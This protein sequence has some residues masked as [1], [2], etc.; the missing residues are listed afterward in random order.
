VELDKDELVT[1][2]KKSV[3]DLQQGVDMHTCLIA[4]ILGREVDQRTL[5][6]VLENCPSRTREM[7]MKDAIM[8]AI[9]ALD[10]SRKAFK[11]KRLENIRKRLMRVLIDARD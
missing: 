7:M 8:E 4:A 2:L 6:P 3:K 9:E 11:S 1:A 5:R 10:E